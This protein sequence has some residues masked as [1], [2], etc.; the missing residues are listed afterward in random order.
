MNTHAQARAPTRT[1]ARPHARTHARTHAHTHAHT[2]TY[3]AARADK[4]ATDA[5]RSRDDIMQRSPPAPPRPPERP[6]P[7]PDEA[8]GPLRGRPSL[9]SPAGQRG[10]VPRPPS[11]LRWSCATRAVCHTGCVGRVQGSTAA[12]TAQP[13]R[14]PRL[15]LHHARTP[16]AALSA[17]PSPVTS[18]PRPSEAP[19]LP[20]VSAHPP[21]TASPRLSLPRSPRAGRPPSVPHPSSRPPPSVPH[22]VP[23]ALTPQPHR[24]DLRRLLLGPACISTQTTSHHRRLP[25]PSHMAPSKSVRVR[26]IPSRESRGLARACHG[27]GRN[28]RPVGRSGSQSPSHSVP[29]TSSESRH[30]SHDYRVASS[31][32]RHPSHLV[33]CTSSDP[34][35]APAE[36]GSGHAA[37]LCC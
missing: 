10:P 30:P 4:T 20:V 16:S 34:S 3:Q 24:T 5:V 29:V 28:T 15:S 36:A 22:H 2:H 19:S 25:Y 13:H 32:P 7:R 1:H 11:P 12:C 6:R 26:P 27:W 31:E 33:R 8:A 37:A 9:P 21:L 17:A 14:V 35:A 23:L 18:A